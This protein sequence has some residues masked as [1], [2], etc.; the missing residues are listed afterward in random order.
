MTTIAATTAR[1]APRVT[2]PAP[3]DR[4]Q[5]ARYRGRACSTPVR[6][7]SRRFIPEP[8]GDIDKTQGPGPGAMAYGVL[9]VTRR[10]GVTVRAPK[11][12]PELTRRASG[13]RRRRHRSDVHERRY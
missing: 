9:A 11:D 5:P 7:D 10:S 4:S 1:P 3:Q 12:P 8:S 2:G 13:A 6:W